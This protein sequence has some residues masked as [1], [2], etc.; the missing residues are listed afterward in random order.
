MTPSLEV[1]G[2]GPVRIFPEASRALAQS[3]V[4]QAVQA[5]GVKP[6]VV[7]IVST[8]GTA[9]ELACTFAN[10]L[11]GQCAFIADDLQQSDKSAASGAIYLFYDESKRSIFLLALDAQGST[12][13]AAQEEYVRQAFALKLEVLLFSSCNMV[14]VVQ[15]SARFTTNALKHV[16]AFATEKQQVVAQLAAASSQK[17]S[18]K[19]D[20]SGSERA[21]SVFTPGRCVP[22]VLFV[23][24]APDEVL[25]TS[26]KLTKSQSATVT[27]CKTLEAKLATLFRSLRGGLVG[28]V[29]MRDALSGPNVS[30]ERRLFN[31]DPTHSVVVVSRQSTTDDGQMETKLTRLLD[32]IDV[33]EEFASVDAFDAHLEQL[34]APL[35]EDDSA[36]GI[37]RAS[38]YLHRFT[39]LLFSSSGHTK[40]AVR[41]ELLGFAQWLKAFQSLVKAFH[42]METKRKQDAVAVA[43]EVAAMGSLEPHPAVYQYD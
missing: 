23:L 9:P 6:V 32:A 39:E 12:P 41:V 37:P 35:D 21:V 26:V 3:P 18:A 27:Y 36:I 10:R 11:I 7:G 17:T 34:L 19:R 8:R 30:K 5:L 25:H 16:R 24:P 29:R 28:S 43:A 14:F 22:L 42:R 38:Q 40:D 4:L 20:K 33:D 13:V 15:P 2:S 31:I 1:C